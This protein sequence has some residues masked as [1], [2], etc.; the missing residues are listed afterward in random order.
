MAM[1]RSRERTFTMPTAVVVFPVPGGP[2]PNAK[3]GMGK[4]ESGRIGT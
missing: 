4:M 1:G 2:S 3:E